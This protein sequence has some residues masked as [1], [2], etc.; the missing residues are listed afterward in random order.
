M[1]VSVVV[2]AEVTKVVLVSNLMLRSNCMSLVCRSISVALFKMDCLPP[3]SK[4]PL[5]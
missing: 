5:T 2:R 1:V 3:M 4:W